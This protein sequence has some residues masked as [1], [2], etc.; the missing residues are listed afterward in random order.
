MEKKPFTILCIDD[1]LLILEIISDYLSD[2]GYDVLKAAN[3][4]E[5]LALFREHHPHAVLVDLRM[6]QVDG[7]EVLSRVTELSPETPVVVVSGTGNIRDVIEALRT[8]AWDYIMKPIEDMRMLA[9][10]VEKSLERSR[11]IRENRLYRENLEELVLK[12]TRELRDSEERFR[13]IAENAR[14]II[15]RLSIPDT[16]FEYISPAVSAI[17]GYEPKDF[18]ADASLFMQIV[19]Q[20]SKELMQELWS[21]VQEGSIPPVIEYQVIHSS[22]TPRWIYQRNVLLKDDAGVPIALECIASDISERKNAETI[23][24]ELIRD[25]ENKNAELER[26]TY[27][28]SHDLRSPLVT[29]KGFIGML[30]EDIKNGHFDNVEADISRISGAADKMNILLSDL[31]EL[32]RIGRVVS[33]RE[34]MSSAKLAG[35]AAELLHGRLQESGA[36]LIIDDTMPDLTGDIPRLREIFQNLL[37]NAVKFMGDREDP[38]IQVGAVMKDG[39]PVI[40]V[41]D[42]GVGIQGEYHEKIFGLFNKLDQKAEGTGVGLALVKRIIEVHGGKIW[43]D[44]PGLGQGATFYF[45]IPGEK[46]PEKRE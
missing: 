14:D 15:A 13:R 10:A 2:M 33:G 35:E 1:E 37:E 11:L 3:G 20:G 45:T 23:R 41:R 22:G 12:R 36:R 25:L 43:V 30:N 39:Q 46:V 17:F 16:R 34:T 21:G 4:R 19:S 27:T 40:F 9:L 29:I 26:F 5:G 32:S 42:N 6:P 24:E 8:G 38:L 28:V 18:Y 44:S 7:L 31:L